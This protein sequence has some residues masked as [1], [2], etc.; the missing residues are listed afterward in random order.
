MKW[1]K[2]Q[3]P[4]DPDVNAITR[5]RGDECGISVSGRITIDSSPGLDALLR[6][7]LDSAGC[8]FLT[9]DLYDVSYMDTSGLAMLVELLKAARTRGKTLRLSGLRE[10]PRYLLQATRL[11]HLFQEE[12]R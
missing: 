12:P 7:S 11:L 10:K 6:R 3:I 2:K 9:V 1:P 5:D 4:L 8:R